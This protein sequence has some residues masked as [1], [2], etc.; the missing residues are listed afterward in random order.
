[1]K[2]PLPS[3]AAPT[4]VR[5]PVVCS[6]GIKVNCSQGGGE[7]HPLTELTFRKGRKGVVFIDNSGN[8][9]KSADKIR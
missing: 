5:R 2:P 6:D 3:L 4:E 7:V 1:M 8:K 9:I